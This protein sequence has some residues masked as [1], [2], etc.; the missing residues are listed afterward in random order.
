M[1]KSGNQTN[2]TSYNIFNKNLNEMDQNN[3]KTTGLIN[4]NSILFNNINKIGGNSN[5]TLNIFQNN[6]NNSSLPTITNN[7]G[8]FVNPNLLNKV[9]PQNTISLPS[10]NMMN[11][12]NFA[13]NNINAIPQNNMVS[14]FIAKRNL[15]IPLVNQIVINANPDLR[16]NSQ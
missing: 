16:L 12:N 10:N 5:T 7:A 9:I 11:P 13:S 2:T 15:P 6:Q 14:P 1:N 4:N 8:N 3:Q